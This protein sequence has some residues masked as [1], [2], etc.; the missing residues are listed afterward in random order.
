M[1]TLMS[2]R[3]DAG[4]SEGLISLGDQQKEAQPDKNETKVLPISL[5]QAFS[6]EDIKKDQE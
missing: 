6:Q 3:H 2:P 4:V 5:E 1:N